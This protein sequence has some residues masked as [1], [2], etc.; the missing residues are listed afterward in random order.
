MRKKNLYLK[1]VC[2]AFLLA[3][4]CILCA[5]CGSRGAA[6]ADG[7]YTV[8]FH[9]DSSMFH[10]NEAYEGKATLTVQDGSM[11]VHITLPSKN[12]V[13]LYPGTAE[14]AQKDGAALLAPTLDTVAYGDGT[15]E[16][17]FGFDIPVPGLDAEFPCALLG[18]KGKWYDHMVS[19]SLAEDAEH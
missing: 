14:D 12:I 3:A 6:L 15:D 9:T 11:R 17:V 8:Y 19:V 4:E 5:A 7:E 18:T 1:A 2:L 13:N 10:V 16:E